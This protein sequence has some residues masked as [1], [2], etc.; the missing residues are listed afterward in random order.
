VYPGST[1][2]T[3]L[4]RTAIALVAAVLSAA[5]A[6]TAAALLAPA[7]RAGW[8]LAAA[9]TAG[10]LVAVTLLG[11]AVGAIR[12]PLAALRDG[13]R[14]FRDGDFSMRLRVDAADEVG[15]LLAMYNQMA[16]ALGSERREIYQ[17]ELLLDALLQ[18]APLAAILTAGGDRVV[19]ANRLARDLLGLGRRLE[20]RR[21]AEVL[22]DGPRELSEALSAS[23][24][25]LFTVRAEAGDETYRAARRTFQISAQPHTL[26]TLERLTPELRRHEVQ[27]W[28]HAIRVINHELNNSFAPIRS[29]VHSAGQALARPEHAHRLGEIFSTISERVTHLA[30]FLQGYAAFARTPQPRKQ[31]VPWAEYLEG[32]RRLV[33]FR[34]EGPLPERP[35]QF[36]PTLLQQVLINLVK[37]AREAGSAEQEV[38]VSVQLAADGGA[39]LRVSDRGRG[40]DE[41][42]VRRALVPFYTSKP[43]GSGLGLPLS[44]EI[45]EA[46]GGRLQLENRPDGGLVVTCRLPG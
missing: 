34:V 27:A 10:G 38:V 45:I 14:S 46:H 6:A 9:L 29:L 3:L 22:A 18:S 25:V 40:M 37:N 11:W 44:S 7:A 20:G 35:G 21:L 41:E 15:E 2:R 24:D 31:E 19:Y 1:Q 26:Y 16:D 39:F 32:V 42:V 33:P 4:V 30:T 17:R 8:V 13:V 28:K 43:G 23:D 36:D 12:G 5:G